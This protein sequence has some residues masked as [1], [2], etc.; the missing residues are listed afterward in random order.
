M[1]AAEKLGKWI[2]QHLSTDEVVRQ[3]IGEKVYPTVTKAEVPGSYV[4]YDNK[5]TTFGGTK[6]ARWEESISVRVLCVAKD[7]TTALALAKLMRIKL[8]GALVAPLGDSLYITSQRDGYDPTTGEFLQELN[9]TI[10]L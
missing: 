8:D 3:A 2:Y 4:V 7:E 9:F 5:T 1:T 10:D 6:D